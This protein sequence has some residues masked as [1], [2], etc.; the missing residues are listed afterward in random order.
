MA[1]HG[2]P[3]PAHLCKEVA[4][5]IRA[6]LHPEQLDTLRSLCGFRAQ[7]L[8][9]PLPVLSGGTVYCERMLPRQGKTTCLMA[10]LLLTALENQEQGGTAVVISRWRSALDGIFMPTMRELCGTRFQVLEHLDKWG[11][12]RLGTWV[13]RFAAEEDYRPL[14]PPQEEA[15]AAP[16]C[17]PLTEA[18]LVLLD[19]IAPVSPLCQRKD[20]PRGLAALVALQSCPPRTE[21]RILALEAPEPPASAGSLYSGSCMELHIRHCSI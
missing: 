4:I 17:P 13:V 11:T 21:L 5:Y 8:P 18:S 2:D 14:P 7:E 15:T 12:L 6:Y 19:H 16:P 1:N 20:C 10:L 9:S 3:L